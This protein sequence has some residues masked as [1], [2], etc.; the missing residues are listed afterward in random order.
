MVRALP[1]HG[2]GCGFESRRFRQLR[3]NEKSESQDS[4]FCCPKRAWGMV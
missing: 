2:R 3:E 4:L 1:C